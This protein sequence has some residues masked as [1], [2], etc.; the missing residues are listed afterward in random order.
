MS[1]DNTSQRKGAGEVF[2][3]KDA[4][5]AKNAKEYWVMKFFRLAQCLGF[6]LSGS[7]AGLFAPQSVGM[8]G[9]EGCSCHGN[10]GVVTVSDNN[11]WNLERKPFK[12]FLRTLCDLCAFALA[13]FFLIQSTS[14][15]AAPDIQHWQTRNGVRVYFVPAAELPIIDVRVVFAAGSARDD[16]K[17]GLAQLSN[18]LLS[19]GADGLDAD[20]IAQRFDSLG[21]QFGNGVDRDMAW[22][23]LRSLSDPKLATP[24]LDLLAKLLSHPDF[25]PQA[26]ERERQRMLIGL[27]QQ[28]ENPQQIAENAFYKAVY[29][30]HP[31]ATPPE[32]TQDSLKALQRDDVLGFYKHYYVAHNA[33]IAIVG[34]L[35]RK[36]AEQLAEKVAGSLPEGVAAPPLPPVK[37]LAA[38]Q[39]IRKQ[40]PSTQTSIFVGQ[41]GDARGDPDYFALYV[42]NHVFG[43]G[44]LVS[45]LSEEIREKRGLSYS[46]Y[47]YFFPMAR[48]GP[49][50]MG[51]QTR[52]DQADEAVRLL[53]ETLAKYLAEGPTDQELT[54]AKRNIT[55]GFPLRIDSNSKILEYLSVIGYYDL[56][57]DY[58][59]TFSRNIEAVSREQAHSAFQQRIHPDKM[60]SVRVGGP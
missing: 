33:L 8:R 22:V 30:N 25:P 60:V 31:Y 16:G 28:E 10:Q 56:P 26:F 17:P 20:A 35:D 23:G 52:N 54:A 6:P 12:T 43:G 15:A 48:K 5:L 34:A 36:G 7:G 1:A 45:R 53:R 19:E 38:A 29:G 59:D 55:G 11:A 50:L 58:L 9:S 46:V 24:A 40:H 4:K 18:G 42:A 51:L 27:Q 37:D 21:A 13:A 3:R 14:A 39:D 49:F 47:S 32:G 2:Q 57:L 44:G 41:P